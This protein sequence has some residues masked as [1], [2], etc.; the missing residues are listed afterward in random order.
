MAAK[1][2]T[3]KKAVAPKK[4]AKKTTTK[5][6]VAPKK[7]NRINFKELSKLLSDNHVNSN[8]IASITHFLQS[9]N[10]RAERFYSAKAKTALSS[11]GI[12]LNDIEVDWN[13][14]FPPIKNSKFTFID[15]FAGI[16]PKFV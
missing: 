5:K 6:A 7:S 14:P 4:V 2:T 1:K 13:V 11:I 15:L 8:D 3:T 12:S 10:T 9:K 16:S